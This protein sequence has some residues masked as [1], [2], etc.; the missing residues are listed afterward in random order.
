MRDLSKMTQEELLAYAQS[1]EKKNGAKAVNGLSFRVG[2]KGGVSVYGLG[3][4]PVTLYQSQ[5]DSLFNSAEALKAFI[6]ENAASLKQK[7]A[8]E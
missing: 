4:F 1:L 7:P 8:A 5:W 3:R 6:T 2:A